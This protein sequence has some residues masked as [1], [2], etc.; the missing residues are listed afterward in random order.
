MNPNAQN[1]HMIEVQCFVKDIRNYINPESVKVI[2][3]IGGRNAMQS[4][5][6]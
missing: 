6:N 5:S 1:F 4:T 2:L 3:D